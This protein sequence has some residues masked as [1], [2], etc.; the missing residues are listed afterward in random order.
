MLD[1]PF[2]VLGVVAPCNYDQGTPL[3]QEANYGGIPETIVVGIG[4]KNLGCSD[5]SVPTIYTRLASYYAWLLQTA[6]QQPAPSRK[7]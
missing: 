5:P 7:L 3:I 1:V 2:W 6:G 4:S